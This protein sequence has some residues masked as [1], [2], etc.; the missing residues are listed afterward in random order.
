MRV[1]DFLAVDKTGFM[2]EPQCVEKIGMR[3][4]S[5]QEISIVSGARLGP[6]GVL[7]K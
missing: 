7:F 1:K 6:P 3:G 5:L 4:F 2:A